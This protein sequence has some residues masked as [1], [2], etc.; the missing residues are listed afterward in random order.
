MTR[1]LGMLLTLCTACASRPSAPSSPDPSGGYQP[2]VGDLQILTGGGNA[3]VAFSGVFNQQGGTCDCLLSFRETAPGSYTAAGDISG[4]MTVTPDRVAISAQ[5][6]SICCGAGVGDIPEVQ[7]PAAV[8]PLE[9]QVS[10]AEVELLDAAQD[11]T[12]ITWKRGQRV[13]AVTA[14]PGLHDFMLARRRHGATVE[15]GLVPRSALT[16]DPPAAH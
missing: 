12:G 6:E 16:C 11:G 14:T 9:C 1:H 2:V 3:L 8:P 7:L 15:L 4:S 13:A 10:E 5:I